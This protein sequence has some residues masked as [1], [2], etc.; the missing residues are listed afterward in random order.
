MLSPTEENYLKTIYALQLDL[1]KDISTNFI[2]SKLHTKASSVSDMLK[3][4]GNKKLIIYKKYQGVKLSV[5][6]NKIALK[7]VRKHRLWE[8]FL[9][10][11]LHFKWDEVHEIA[12]QLEHV[13][14]D[15]LVDKL[16]RFLGSP[17]FDP[18]GD[19]IPDKYGNIVENNAVNILG[20]LIGQEGKLE[21][22]KDS[23]EVFLRYLNNK[24][25]AL[26]DNIKV[27]EIEPF[28]NSIQIKTKSGSITISKHVAE[29]L[30]LKTN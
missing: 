22:V 13:R 20:M 16:D 29:N 23:S 25:L 28:D 14:S 30:Y 18:H 10:K 17:K 7:I 19:P 21:C 2:A 26:G 6:G 12:E 27:I 1:D 15:D 4:L 9:V 3:K 8:C 24:N 11:E 5:K